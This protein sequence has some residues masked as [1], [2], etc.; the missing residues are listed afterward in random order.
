M[1]AL[2]KPVQ[3]FGTAE[4]VPAAEGAEAP[5]DNKTLEFLEGAYD[6]LRI[7]AALYNRFGGGKL[8]NMPEDL[9]AKKPRM[10]DKTFVRAIAPAYFDPS[11]AARKA[12]D[13]FRSPSQI[14][15]PPFAPPQ[16][17]GK[18]TDVF[19]LPPEITTPPFAPPQ[20]TEKAVPVVPYQVG[21]TVGG[22]AKA[23]KNGVISKESMQG[24]L[25][26]GHKLPT[27]AELEAQGFGVFEDGM[28]RVTGYVK[29]DGTTVRWELD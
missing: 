2:S 8:P 5:R 25:K 6:V 27:K 12:A 24:L 18:A 29:P 3:I 22:D 19:G 21:D 1:S 11:Q 9:V 16:A 14:S 20:A 7:G 26:Q 13:A 10:A 4:Q 23:V 28:G 15:T 17:T